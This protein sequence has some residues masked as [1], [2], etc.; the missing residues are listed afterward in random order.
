[1]V[2]FVKWRNYENMTYIMQFIIISAIIQTIITGISNFIY[3]INSLPVLILVPLGEIPVVAA[4]MV[5]FSDFFYQYLYIKKQEKMIKKSEENITP[6]S[7]SFSIYIASTMVVIC[8]ILLNFFFNY[9]IIDPI[10]FHGIPTYSQ[11]TLSQTTSALIIIII[12][13]ILKEIQMSKKRG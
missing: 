2:M 10:W 3:P 11:F 6:V 13:T 9:I 12:V 4:S 1:M 5:I 8:F 7:K